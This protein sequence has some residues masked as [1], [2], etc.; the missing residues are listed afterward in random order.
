[1]I[2]GLTSAGLDSEHTVEVES[3]IARASFGVVCQ[4]DFDPE[5]HL[6]EDKVM[7][8]DLGRFVVTKRMKWFITKV[9]THH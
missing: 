2:H 3:R 5:K 1:M 7:D 9:R 6:D 8:N 4:E